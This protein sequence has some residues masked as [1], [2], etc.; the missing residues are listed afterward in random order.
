MNASNASN[1]SNI[2]NRIAKK[3]VRLALVAAV[4]FAGLGMSAGHAAAESPVEPVDGLDIAI[5]STCPKNGK[6][7]VVGSHDSITV[8]APDGKLIAGYCVKAGSA[9]QGLGPETVWLDPAVE[10]VIFSHSSGKDIS[11]YTVFFIDEPIDDKL[12]PVPADEPEM[13]DDKMAPVPADEPQPLPQPEPQP[14]PESEVEVQVL[15]A[16]PQPQPQPQPESKSQPQPAAP[17][18]V[19]AAGPTDVSVAAGSLPVT[20]STT[21]LLAGLAA[22]IAALG[23]GVRRVA[24]RAI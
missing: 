19:P 6:I 1:I 14:E 7:D 5:E 2:S 17:V 8:V 9:Q 10:E 20:G 12:A 15:P 16:D 3:S 21:T 4:S 18:D 13:P 24:R 22:G 23:C 11:H